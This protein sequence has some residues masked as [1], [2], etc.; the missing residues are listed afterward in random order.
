MSGETP[1]RAELLAEVAALRRQLSQAAGTAA[2]P[3]GLEIEAQYK[4]LIDACPDAVVMSDL[5]GKVLWASPQTWKLLGLSEAEQLVGQS[6]LDYVATV[7]RPRLAANMAR[8]ASTGDRTN[9]EYQALRRD[10]S[11]VPIETSSTLI[12]DAQGRPKALMAVIRDISRRKQA[13]AALAESEAK[14]RHLVETTDTGYLILDDQAR[15]V[16]ANQEYVRISGHQALAE[17]LGRSVFEWTAPHD[18][19]RNQREFAD[20]L[21][22]GTVHRLEI[23][24]VGPGGRVLPVE[25]N[26]CCIDTKH[27][28]RILSLCRDISER[29]T[30]QDELRRERQTLEYLLRSSDHERRLIAYEIHDGLA[31]YLAAAL[32]QLDT[33]QRLHDEDH[34]AAMRACTAGIA[35]ARESLAETRRLITGLRPPILD[36]LGLVAAVR[37][38]AAEFES[39]SGPQIEVHTAVTFER[40]PPVLE[41]SAYRIVQEGL[42]N[43]WK[44]SHT[45]RVRVELVQRGPWL[46]IG[47]E[48]WGIGFN[49]DDVDESRFGLAGIRQRARLL[50]GSAIIDSAPGKG[51]RIVVELPIVAAAADAEHG[52]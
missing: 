40:L 21:R 19:G 22:E 30:A 38:L 17:I 33:A 26:G 10:G 32:M 50:A 51:T 47:V 28:R 16:D 7:D 52:A 49:L 11:S 8:V 9:T 5:Q 37:H 34:A 1:S 27:G 4:S 23:D 45:Q 43:A 42:T 13:E 39:R 25:I 46:R 6:V 36:E 14:Y 3:P 2:G 31:Q 24:Y 41:N 29:R 44:H 18:A 15:V 35:M 20:C 12:R 48:D